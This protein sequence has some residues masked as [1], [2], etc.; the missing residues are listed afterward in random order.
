[1]TRVLSTV[2]SGSGPS[3]TAINL[4]T[5]TSHIRNPDGSRLQR[6]RCGCGTE[7]EAVTARGEAKHARFN[8]YTAWKEH[9]RKEH[10]G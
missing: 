9:C 1:M 10:S 3:V 4:L 8:L 5:Y 2:T 6:G 7:L